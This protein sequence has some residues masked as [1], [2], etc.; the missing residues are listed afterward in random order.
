MFAANTDTAE[1]DRDCM[2]VQQSTP[3][4][5]MKYMKTPAVYPMFATCRST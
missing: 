3:T 5:A 4:Q 2:I 1:L